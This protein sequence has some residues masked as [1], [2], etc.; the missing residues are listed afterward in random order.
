MAPS[1]QKK[2][3]AFLEKG[4][5]I[6]NMAPSLQK[7]YTAFLEKGWGLGKGKYIDA[8]VRLFTKKRSFPLPQE[9]T[10]LISAK[11]GYNKLK[12]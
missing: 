10:T 1:L 8:D 7:K 4:C 9:P 6:S 2:Y 12:V 5:V 3:T 11:T